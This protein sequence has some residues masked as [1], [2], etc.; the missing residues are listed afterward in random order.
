MKMSLKPWGMPE[1]RLF[2]SKGNRKVACPV[3]SVSSGTNC[4][5]AK[6]CPY[7]NARRGKPHP[8]I[9]CYAQKMERFRP[10][11]AE[12]RD[13][14]AAAIKALGTNRAVICDVAASFAA[15]LEKASR[16]MDV[17]YVRLNES[18]D[19]AAG[20]IMFLEELS[21][22]LR[23]RDVRPYLYTRSQESLADRMRYAGCIVLESDKDF[24]VVDSKEEAKK[25]GLVVCPG[26]GCGKGCLRCMKENEPVLTT[27]VVKH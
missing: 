26:K 8:E 14:N 4:I 11:I 3:F 27:A 17:C 16:L 19:I 22:E 7:S 5:H 1:H 23:I 25:L 2:F 9:W 24:V 18:G 6:T 21:V 10:H 13:L 20:N 15:R 12:A